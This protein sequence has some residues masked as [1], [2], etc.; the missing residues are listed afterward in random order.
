MKIFK[1]LQDFS[2][3]YIIFPHQSQNLKIFLFMAKLVI[4]VAPIPQPILDFEANAKHVILSSINISVYISKKIKV[5][6]KFK[7]NNI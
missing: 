3:L 7:N 6:F 1:F 2:K 4:S 5:L